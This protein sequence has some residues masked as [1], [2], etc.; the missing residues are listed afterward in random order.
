MFSRQDVWVT[1][2]GRLNDTFM[3]T[4]Y[5]NTRSNQ[6]LIPRYMPLSNIKTAHFLNSSIIHSLL[7]QPFTALQPLSSQLIML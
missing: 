3:V 4:K 5:R 7:L 1:D 2:F 6:S